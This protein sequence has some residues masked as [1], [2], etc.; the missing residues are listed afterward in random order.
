MA[1]GLLLPCLAVTFLFGP[2]GYLLFQALRLSLKSRP[3]RA[4]A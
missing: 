3:A 1:H 2:A 4:G